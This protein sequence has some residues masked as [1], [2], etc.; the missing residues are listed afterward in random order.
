MRTIEVKVYRYSELSDDAKQ[1]AKEWFLE[2][3]I[4]QEFAWDGM[5]DD[6]KNVGIA[7]TAWDY[8]RY[9]EGKFIPPFSEVI[10]KILSEHGEQCETYKTANEYKSKFLALNDDQDDERTE[11]EDEF[12]HSI[13]EDYRIMMDGEVDFHQTDEYISDVMEANE[14][15]F[16][17][18]GKR[19]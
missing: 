17:E 10:D 14:Y 5:K 11:L 15:E 19:A 1:K 3:G 2:G 7:L 16:L 13:L 6:A 4:D 8:G 9:C 12:L 18:N